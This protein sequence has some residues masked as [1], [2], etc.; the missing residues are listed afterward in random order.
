MRERNP[1]DIAANN[2]VRLDLVP[3]PAMVTTAQALADGARKYGPYNWRVTPIE[4]SGYI[5]AALRH[6]KS[7]QDREELASDSLVHHL[8]H[9][10]ATLAILQDALACGTLIDDRPPV[11]PTA[12]LLA[13]ASVAK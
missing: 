7:W 8:G 3:G 13:E 1:K 5:A 4:A 9:A 2:R 12:R 10:M 11:G 6:I